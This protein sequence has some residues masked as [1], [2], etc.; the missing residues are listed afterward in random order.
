MNEKPTKFFCSL[1]KAKY[2]D[3]TIKKIILPNG[4]LVQSQKEIL[5]QIKHYYTDIFSCKDRNCTDEENLE[6]LFTTKRKLAM[7][8][9]E[10][11]NGPITITE[12]GSIVKN[13]KNNK[14]PGV[15]SF[16]ADF[17]KVFLERV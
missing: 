9:S 5:E 1:E 10:A 16:P 17:I 13:M 11:L 4:K 14:T 8:E 7:L 2:I 15:D 6:D 3:K 12:L